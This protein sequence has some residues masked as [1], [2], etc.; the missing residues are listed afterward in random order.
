MSLVGDKPCKTPYGN[1]VRDLAG[2]IKK[3][4]GISI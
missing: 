2:Y 3:S 1:A 4:E